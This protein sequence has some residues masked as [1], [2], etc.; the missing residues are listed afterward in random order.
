MSTHVAIVGAYG[1]AG[2]AVAD[3]LVDEP[4]IELSLIDDGDPG[5]G[6]CILRGCMP[7]KEL[8]SAAAHRHQA[9]HDDRLVG[10]PPQVDLE[11][12]VA[13]KDDRTLGWAGHR[14][15]QVHEWAEREDV[16]LYRE[17]A[18]FVDDRTLLV[19]DARIEPDY[20]V[21]ATGS[22]VNVPDIPGIDAVEH[23]TSADVLDATEL[24]DSG[25]VIGFGYIGVEMAPYLAEAGEMD[26]TVVEHDD[27]PLD[28]ADPVFG[29]EIL[30]IYREEF[31]IEVLMNAREQRLEK[32]ETGVRLSLST[33]EGREVIE[34]EQLVCFTGRR[35][36]ID[37]LGLDAAGI[38][39]EGAWVEETM[40]ARDNDRVYVVGDANGKEPILH[41]AKEQGHVAA[42]NI[43]RE[44]RGESLRPYENIHHHVVF[45]GLGVY[46][47]ARVGHTPASARDAGH[48]VAV[49]TRRASDDGIFESKGV[50]AGLA[51]LVV[52]RADGTVLGYQGLH[53]HADTMAKTA[54]VL[55]ELG[56]DAR[57][58]PDRAYHPTLPE[59]FDG[60]LRGAVEQLEAPGDETATEEPVPPVETDG[61]GAGSD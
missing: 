9:R 55:V 31:D 21:L 60:L 57:S 43:R 19:G 6:L 53:Y 38:D 32:T 42:E 20:V 23:M 25:I 13:Q 17:P 44:L 3:R 46:P 28:E 41:V 27:R 39:P 30:D 7:S 48:E 50:P 52:D 2:S 11:E 26:L 61:S 24:P 10:D 56:L 47:F 35:P 45:S 8:L 18:Q 34:A 33:P 16:H 29:D 54:Q 36:N 59:L 4:N 58:V 12:T 40:R 5:G 51:R 37:G 49:A 1:S 22:R 14:R 15:E